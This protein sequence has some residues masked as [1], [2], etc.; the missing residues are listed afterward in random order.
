MHLSRLND[1]VFVI[2][3]LHMFIEDI[4]SDLIDT[5]LSVFKTHSTLDC[6]LYVQ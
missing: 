3:I 6:L 2:Y 4:M 1:Q 5:I